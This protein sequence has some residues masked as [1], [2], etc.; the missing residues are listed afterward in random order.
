MSAEELPHELVGPL[1]DQQTW[2]VASIS[3]DGT[4]MLLVDA[5]G[6]EMSVAVAPAALPRRSEKTPVNQPPSLRPRDI[7]A[8]IRSGESP[9]SV[10]EAAGTSLERIMPFAAPVMAEREHMAGRAQKASVRRQATESTARTLGD[11][12]ALQ[13]AA[14]DGVQDSLEWDAWRRTDGRWALVALYTTAVRSGAAEFTFDPPGNFVSLD[15]DDARWLVGDLIIE[16][17]PEPVLDDLSAARVRREVREDSP[18]EDEGATLA[19]KPTWTPA[20]TPGTTPATTPAS[21]PVGAPATPDTD[22]AVPAVPRE[23]IP[24]RAESAPTEA[25]PA[26]PPAPKKPKRRG[27]ASI[28]SWDEIMFG[29]SG[30]AAPASDTDTPST[31]DNNP[32]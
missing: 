20:T 21:G 13:F 17:P 3:R 23:E 18:A 24:A 14:T 25:A 27:R 2:T 5:D 15:N 7:Q 9:E 28:P 29:G 26:A 22:T 32:A 6:N 31:T 10:A 19:P 1:T 12:V 11:A 8:R 30:D 16:T 4:R